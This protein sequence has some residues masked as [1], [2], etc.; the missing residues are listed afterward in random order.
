MDEDGKS[1][2]PLLS[3]EQVI[4]IMEERIANDEPVVRDERIIRIERIAEQ[5]E[6]DLNKKE[7]A[8][9]QGSRPG[10]NKFFRE[11]FGRIKKYLGK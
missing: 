6:T 4:E 7:F 11:S 3:Y 10:I 8:K 2:K 1:K 9:N 5:M